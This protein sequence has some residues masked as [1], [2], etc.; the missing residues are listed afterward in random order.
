MKVTD[1]QPPASDGSDLAVNDD[2]LD[3]SDQSDQEEPSAF[4]QVLAR[5]RQAN[6]E[7]SQAKGKRA[8]SNADPTAGASAAVQPTFEQAMQAA[9]VESKHVVAVPPEIEQLV[10]EISV[11]VGPEGKQEVHIEMNSNVLDGLQI[12]IDRQD[13]GIRVQ[14]QSASE[15]VTALVSNNI[16]ALAQGLEDRGVAVAGIRVVGPQESAR[17]QRFGYRSG[18]GGNQRGGQGGRR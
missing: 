12:V 4:S 17:N 15:Q 18:S 5:K 11:V 13:A 14:F 1:P 9:P 3:S 7:G 2:D 16:A 6:Q 10:D 8:D